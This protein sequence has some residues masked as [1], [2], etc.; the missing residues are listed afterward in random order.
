MI[1]RRGNSSIWEYASELIKWVEF[2]ASDIQGAHVELPFRRLLGML[3][4]EPFQR[5]GEKLK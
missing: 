2:T 5:L 4:R 1:R 3:Q